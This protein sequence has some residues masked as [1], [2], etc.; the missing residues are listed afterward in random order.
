[1]VR[2]EN[3]AI[4][5]QILRGRLPG[6]CFDGNRH[7]AIPERV[8]ALG[9]LVDD[10]AGGDDVVV[11]E[12]IV[13]AALEIFVPDIASSNDADFVVDDEELVM[14]PIVEPGRIAQKL[15]DVHERDLS[16]VGKRIEDPQFDIRV[17]GERPDLRFAT[18]RAGVVEQHANPHA[19]IGRLEQRLDQQLAGIVALNEEVLDVQRSSGGFRHF[20]PQQETLDA[21][22]QQ[23]E[24]GRSR[25]LGLC[26]GQLLSQARLLRAGQGARRC[27]RIIGTRRQ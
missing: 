22:R 8:E 12:F 10:R 6:E 27:L 26:R 16:A 7:R 13:A 14:H 11:A 3:A 25:M 15:R 24:A 23:L 18:E 19:A 4:V 2:G 1:M 9:D 21:N 17:S 5:V 20:H